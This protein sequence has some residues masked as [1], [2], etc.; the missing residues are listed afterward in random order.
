MKMKKIYL[1]KKDIIRF[2]KVFS[3]YGI[4]FYE[5]KRGK[6]FKSGEIIATKE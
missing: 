4:G 3:K 2:E 1:N 5:D 6:Y